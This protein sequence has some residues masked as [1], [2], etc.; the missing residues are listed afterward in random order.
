V[1]ACLAFLVGA[2]F[3]AM[4]VNGALIQRIGEPDRSLAFWH[5]PVLFLGLG[6]LALGGVLWLVAGARAGG[7]E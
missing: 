4:Y 6:G 7:A 3:C 1:L 2:A 5:L